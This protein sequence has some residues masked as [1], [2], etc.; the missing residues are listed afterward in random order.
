MNCLNCSVLNACRWGYARRNTY[1]KQVP[2]YKLVLSASTSPVCQCSQV[3]CS[4]IYGVPWLPL[5]DLTGSLGW[6]TFACCP[7]H[8]CWL[9]FSI[10]WGIYW[11]LS[12]VVVF[13]LQLA[14][15]LV[16]YAGRTVCFSLHWL[17]WLLWVLLRLLVSVKSLYTEP[18]QLYLLPWLRGVRWPFPLYVLCWLKKQPSTY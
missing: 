17:R 15:G 11:A 5:L 14:F 1:Q 16:C 13:W 6:V 8:I 3:H 18:F 10:V 7:V 2:R 9:L 12:I 4:W